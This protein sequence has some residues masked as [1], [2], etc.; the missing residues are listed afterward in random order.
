M[1]VVNRCYHDQEVGM[2]QNS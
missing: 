1:K 2:I